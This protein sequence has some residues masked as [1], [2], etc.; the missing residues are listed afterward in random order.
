[1]RAG[2]KLRFNRD[3]RPLLS[4]RCFYCHGPDEKK[5]EA[6]LRLDT[7]E[8]ATAEHDGEAAIVPGQSEK[9]GLLAR[10]A[11]HDRDEMMPPPKTKWRRCAAGSP[12]VR[13]TK[14][15]GRFSH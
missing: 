6:K 10:I 9:S 2:E 8:G 7:R 5:R 1:V 12:R 15:I 11:S 13:N 4:D 14:G 3:I